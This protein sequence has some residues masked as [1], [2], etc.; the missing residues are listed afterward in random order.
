MAA[1]FDHLVVSVADLDAAAARW[2]AAGL[3][4]H[5]GG[6]H[7]GGTVNAL[8]RGPR[9]GYVELISTEPDARSDWADRV[10]GST[11]PLG[12]AVAVD[13]IAAARAALIDAGFTP[14]EVTDGSRAT[15]DGATLRWRMCQVGPVAFDPELPFLIEWITPMPPGPDD[16]PV[17][18]AIGIEVPDPTRLAT[19]LRTVGF[20]E[21]PGDVPWLTFA[22]GEVTITLATSPEHHGVTAVGFGL[23]H[24][25]GSWQDLDGLYVSTSPDVRS[26]R[27]HVLLPTVEEHFADRDPALATWPAPHPERAPL[28]EEYSRCLD[29]GKYRI[30]AARAR[31]WTAA[32]AERG[33]AEVSDTDGTLTIT[34]HAP[35]TLPVQVRFTGFDGVDDSGVQIVATGSGATI[36]QLPVCGCDACD[37]GSAPLLR[38]IDDT[39]LHLIDGGVLHIADRRGRTVTTTLDG[40]AASGRFRDGE[41][42]RWIADVDAGRADRR[43]VV[44]RGKPWI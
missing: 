40:W 1:R 10:R 8:I 7:P 26:H 41:P 4:P 31:A 38:E 20:P 33:I 16:G 32:L 3:R 9:T 37:D 39:F 29:P 28:E 12:F 34:P 24:G 27:G 5:R 17:V 42:E 43:W 11:G 19:L 18:E 23:A 13:D 14:R 35:D 25:A 15:V 6:R 44:T 30:I 21:Q 36:T 2:A 22:D